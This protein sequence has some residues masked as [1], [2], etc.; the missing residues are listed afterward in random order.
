MM[1][2]DDDDA[3][4]HKFGEL[5]AVRWPTRGPVILIDY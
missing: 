3:V 4:H 2:Y 5:D 1:P